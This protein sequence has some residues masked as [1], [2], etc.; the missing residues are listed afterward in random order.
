V[1]LTVKKAAFFEMG[2]GGRAIRS[3]VIGHLCPRCLVQ[4]QDYQRPAF[5]TPGTKPVMR[6]QHG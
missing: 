6:P 3:R 1:L 2:V 5:D 4:D